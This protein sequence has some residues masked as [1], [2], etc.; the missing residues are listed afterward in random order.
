MRAAGLWLALALAWAWAAPGPALSDA[1]AGQERALLPLRDIQTFAEVF[2]HIKTSYVEEVDDKTLF[3]YAIQG[4]LNGLDPHSSYLDE[5]AHKELGITANGQFGGLGME[6][7]MQ[8]DGLARVIAPIDDTPAQ[9]AGIESGDK[10]ITVDGQPIRNML[11]TDVLELLRGKPGTT[12]SIEVLRGVHALPFHLVR[13]IINIRSVRGRM[14]A[15]GFGY[16]RIAQ[17]Q[18][19]TAPEMVT[20]IRTLE[21]IAPLD[22]L[23]IDVR[24][25]PGGVLHAAVS[26]ADLFLERGIIVYTEG[27]HAQSKT[28][29][30]AGRGDI[31]QGKPIVLLINGGSASASEILAGALQD[32]RRAVIVGETSFGKGSAQNVLPLP[33]GGAIKLTMLRYF[34]PKGRSIQAAGVEPDI[35]VARAQ[36]TLRDDGDH[37][38]ESDL[39][40]HLIAEIDEALSNAAADNA[41]V[42]ES[43]HAGQDL[44]AEDNQLFEA[45][46]LAKGMHLMELSRNEQDR[47]RQQAQRKPAAKRGG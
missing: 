13:D 20:Q 44:L 47:Q 19:N 30:S 45:L 33:D 18:S 24:N 26:A 15:P 32:Y 40:K 11:L 16:L 41:R 7:S 14:L 38:K 21:D 8:A 3:R 2:Q 31:M 5:R 27:R 10:I 42:D 37:L 25:N 22:G 12:V 29:Y 28:R 9:R 1:D 34:T 36:M 17:F 6:I 46:N 39:P 43:D 35:V 4:M 23:V